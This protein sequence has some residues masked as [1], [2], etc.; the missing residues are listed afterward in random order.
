MV[1]IEEIRAFYW[2]FVRAGVFYWR[3]YENTVW[4]EKMARQ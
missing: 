3:C 4:N 2:L 1:F